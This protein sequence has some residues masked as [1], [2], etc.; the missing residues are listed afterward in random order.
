R[1]SRDWSSD[2]CSSDL[3][4]VDLAHA[5][6]ADGGK[7]LEAVL[8]NGAGADAAWFLRRLA[9]NAGGPAGARGRAGR[10]ARIGGIAGALRGHVVEIGRASC[11]EGVCVGV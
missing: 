9:A 2:V 3:G 4:L 11:R 10:G 8:E 6:L 5:A 7:Q 1:F